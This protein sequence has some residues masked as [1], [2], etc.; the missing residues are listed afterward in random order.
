M[1]RELQNTQ[2]R[3]MSVLVLLC[4]TTSDSLSVKF[5]ASFLWFGSV[6]IL[7]FLNTSVS[8]CLFVLSPRFCYVVSFFSLFSLIF[9]PSIFFSP[10]SVWRMLDLTNKK[11]SKCFCAHRNNDS[12]FKYMWRMLFLCVYVYFEK[13]DDVFMEKG[14][15]W[16]CNK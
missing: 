1:G 9:F 2:V 4:A 12:W 14:P 8:T 16:L 5:W 13:R 3:A 11:W 6:A 10:C 15:T 7:Q